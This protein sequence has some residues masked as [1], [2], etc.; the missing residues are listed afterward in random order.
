MPTFGNV[1]S[2]RAGVLAGSGGMCEGSMRLFAQWVSGARAGR[3]FRSLLGYRVHW[4]DRTA[5]G[6]SAALLPMDDCASSGSDAW[7]FQLGQP[8][9]MGSHGAFGGRMTP[10]PET[11]LP[12]TRVRI[13]GPMAI[14]ADY[15][16]NQFTRVLG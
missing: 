10:T 13:H 6:R 7:S 12:G 9:K 3:M 2:V 11:A 14:L 16:M 1:A 8:D 5:N 4:P 15:R